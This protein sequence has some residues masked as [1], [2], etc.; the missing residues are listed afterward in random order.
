[1]A[2]ETGPRLPSSS[3]R[4]NDLRRP[5]ALEFGKGGA[6]AFD[7]GGEEVAGRQVREGQAE[8]SSEGIDRGQE[9]VSLGGQDAL[10]K[11]GAGAQDLGHLALDELAGPGVLHLVADGDLAAGPQEPADV[12]MGGVE[13]DAAHR[14]HAPFRQRHIEQL[15]AGLGVL[16]KHLVEIAQAEKQQRVPG[17]LALDAAIL[18]H[19]G[20]KLG[21]AGHRGKR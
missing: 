17:Q 12:G 4:V 2:A 19:H 3:L 8:G 11:V 5:Q 1:V 20:G 7:F 6:V 14:N 18:R 13:G 21:V 10:V 9:V 15:G 16:E